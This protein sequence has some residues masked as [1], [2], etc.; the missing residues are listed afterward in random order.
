MRTEFDK[1]PQRKYPRGHCRERER[2]LQEL[3]KSYIK[4]QNNNS[5]RRLDHAYNKIKIMQKGNTLPWID[6]PQV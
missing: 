3:R 6:I 4:V 1:E 5:L 2:M